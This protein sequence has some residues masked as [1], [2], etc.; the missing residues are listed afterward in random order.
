[1]TR[2]MPPV[3]AEQ[4]WQRQPAIGRRPAED[5]VVD[6]R[7]RGRRETQHEAVEGEMM[8]EPAIVGWPLI[9]VVATDPATIQIAQR[10]GVPARLPERGPR[11]C[12][13]AAR[14]DLPPKAPKA[15]DERGHGEEKCRAEQSSHRLVRHQPV[16][17]SVPREER[18]PVVPEREAQDEGCHARCRHRRDRQP[19]AVEHRAKKGRPCVGAIRRRPHLRQCLRHVDV[20]FVRRR[21]LAVD[22][23]GPAPVAEIGEVIEIGGGEAASQLHRREHRAKSFAIAAGVADRHQPPGFLVAVSRVHGVPLPRPRFFRRRCRSS[24]RCRRCSPCRARCRP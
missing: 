12:R 20:E 5:I 17:M 19:V 8:K 14:A 13:D 24:C 22:V 21:K 2:P 18:G 6:R 16:E 11:S 3:Y 7:R 4:L 1:M 9:F 10:G 23:A 15:H